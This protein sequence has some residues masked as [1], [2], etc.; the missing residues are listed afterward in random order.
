[1]KRVKYTRYYLKVY[2][3]VRNLE[4]ILPSSSEFVP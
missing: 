2:C 1:M 4:S 3:F